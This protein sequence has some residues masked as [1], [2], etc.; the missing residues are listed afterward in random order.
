YYKALALFESIPYWLNY[1]ESK[2]LIDHSTNN[3]IRTSI[4]K[5]YR[6]LKEIFNIWPYNDAFVKSELTSAWGETI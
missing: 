6:Y 5:I 2:Q 4:S 3:E 1:L